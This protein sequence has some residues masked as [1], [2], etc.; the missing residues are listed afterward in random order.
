M[1]DQ[2][3]VRYSLSSTVIAQFYK[4]NY[5][6]IITINTGKLVKLIIYIVKLTI[7]DEFN[8]EIQRYH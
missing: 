7:E 5:H 8:P 3:E 4:V 6:E 1:G 2:N